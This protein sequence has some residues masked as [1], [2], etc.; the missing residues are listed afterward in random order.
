K[1]EGFDSCISARKRC[2]ARKGLIPAG[3]AGHATSRLERDVVVQLVRAAGTRAARRSAATR[4][5]AAAI[6]AAR[7]AAAVAVVIAAVAALVAAI[8]ATTAAAARTAAVA[9]VKQRQRSGEGTQ[10]DLGR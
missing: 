3:M 8:A 6:A 5:G 10:H 2:A 7:T 9:A 4:P 1:A